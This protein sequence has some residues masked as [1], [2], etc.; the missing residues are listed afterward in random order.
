M[1]LPIIR[2][3]AYVVYGSDEKQPF[4]NVLHF[5]QIS[6]FVAD[7]AECQALANELDININSALIA[8]LPNEASYLRSVVQLYN[9]GL[10]Y[11]RSAN[12]NAGQGGAPDEGCPD[13]VAVVI[14]KRT[15]SPGKAG[16]GRWY[17]GCVSE[18]YNDTGRLTAP[19]VTVYDA[20]AN[21]LSDDLVTASGT[22][23]NC[24][25]SR[26]T[27]VLVPIVSVETQPIMCTQRRRRLQR[28][29]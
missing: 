17:V 26:S 3:T 22:W 20:L 16:R 13:Y 14:R 6:T 2:A 4:V 25:L 29:I 12:T 23:Q 1:P 11:E 15:D 18:E 28:G 5:R 8:V 24:H 10:S 9:D 19:G 7:G 27:S 21:A